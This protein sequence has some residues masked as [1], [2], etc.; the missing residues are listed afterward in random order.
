MPSKFKERLL[1]RTAGVAERAE[2]AAAARPSESQARSATM[3]AQLSAFRLEAR[4]Y[5][6]RI[7]QLQEELEAAKRHGGAMK[8]PLSDLHEVPGRRRFKSPE[9]YAELR[10][11]LRHNALITPVAIRPRLEGGFELVSGHWRTDAYRELGRTEIDCVLSES[12]ETEASL[13]AFYANLLQSDLTDY[14]K[15]LGFKDIQQRFEGITQAKMAEQ[16]GV[17]E[18]AIS[19][20]MAYSDLPAEVLAML[21]EKPGLFGATSGTALARLVRTGRSAQ[22]IAA[23]QRLADKQFDETQAVKFASTDPAKEKPRPIPT[24]FKV[25]AGRSTYCDVRQA[26]NVVRLEFQSEE[27]AK[28]MQ[29]ALKEVLERRAAKAQTESSPD[30]GK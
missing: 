11:N 15:Y 19:R 18:A 13:G 14:E 22:V 12:T 25:K 17:G 23:V 1:S 2:S 16:A 10:E 20:L 3:P 6:E 8:V 30:A 28:A 26:K 9:A 7:Q 4:G 5:Q 27:E 29:G 21:D 24:A